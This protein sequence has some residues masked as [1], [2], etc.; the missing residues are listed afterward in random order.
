MTK[1]FVHK[2]AVEG[3]DYNPER[4]RQV[5]DA[6][7]DQDRI[8]G[9]ENQRGINSIAYRPGPYS[10]TF[11]FGVINFMDWYTDTAL[12]NLEK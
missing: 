8:L 4:L 1:W 11:E 2:D 6:T 3:V 7:N 12:K 10:K 9:E 5:W